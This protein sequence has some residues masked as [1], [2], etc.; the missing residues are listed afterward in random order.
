M[1]YTWEPRWEKYVV[2]IN[3][4][5]IETCKDK[6]TGMIACPICINAMEKC[7][8]GEYIP[9][10]N[11]ENSFFFSEEDLIRHIRDYHGGSIGRKK[12]H[13]VKTMKKR[14]KK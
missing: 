4:I 2:E 5:R 9:G 3:G 13:A 12:Y 10:Y 11:Y 1:A 7:L 14:R 6:I 8:G